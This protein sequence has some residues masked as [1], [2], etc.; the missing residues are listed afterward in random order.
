[1]TCVYFFHHRPYGKTEAVYHVGITDDPVRRQ[2]SIGRTWVEAGWRS[3]GTACLGK[4]PMTGSATSDDEP[5]R[6]STDIGD[7][8]PAG[9][10]GAGIRDATNRGRLR[11]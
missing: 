4:T 2:S 10:S 3:Y 6:P 8:Y 1:M 7:G 9:A 11:R 5:R